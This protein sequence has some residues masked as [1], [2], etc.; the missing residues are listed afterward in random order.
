MEKEIKYLNKLAGQLQSSKIHWA[1]STSWTRQ[2]DEGYNDG[3]QLGITLIE[4]RI[5]YL[6]RQSKKN[7]NSRRAKKGN[8][9]S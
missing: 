2:N 8:R 7:G 3:L 1:Q 5:K 9:A 4:R 6:E